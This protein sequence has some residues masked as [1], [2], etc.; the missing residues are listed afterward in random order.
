M[1]GPDPP[2]D[3]LLGHVFGQGHVHPVFREADGRQFYLL[4]C[5]DGRERVHGDSSFLDEGCTWRRLDEGLPDRRRNWYEERTAVHEAGHAVIGVDQGIKV[6]YVTGAVA[7]WCQFDYR[8]RERLRADWATWGEKN[9][10]AILGGPDAERIFWEWRGQQLPEDTN[11]GWSADLGRAKEVRMARDGP[12]TDQLGAQTEL[13]RLQ[14]VDRERLQQ[15]AI[16]AAVERVAE[17]LRAEGAIDGT[18][19]RELVQIADMQMG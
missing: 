12:D 4:Q 18:T 14:G 11:H 1:P 2:L 16:W 6:E 3:D 17:R 9:M 7:F 8:L 13:V 19:V 10:K 5:E 15:P